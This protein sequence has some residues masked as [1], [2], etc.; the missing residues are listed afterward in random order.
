M[1]S[2]RGSR[3]AYSGAAIPGLDDALRIFE[4]HPDQCGLALYFAD[5]LAAL[6]VVPHPDDYRLLHPTLLQDLYG[7]LLYQYA[8]AVPVR[9]GVRGDGGRRR[10]S[11]RWPTCGRRSR[12]RATRVGR[13]PRGDGGRAARRAEPHPDAGVP[14]W[15][16]SRWSRFLPPFDLDRENHL[17]EIIRDSRRPGLAYLKT[18]RL[19]AAQTRR[20]HLLS[21][22]AAHDWNLDATATALGTDR[23]GLTV[24]LDRAG[25]GY[26]LRPDIIDACRN[27]LR[28]ER[29]T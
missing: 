10:M 17:G 23:H 3:R 8:P 5:A 22:L 20:G 13:V 7:D 28:K 15:A 11:A 26:L 19:S 24:R 2:H 25:F 1:G 4:I 14:R 29:L 6:F 21:L 16:G 27:R 9:A 18:F 12:G